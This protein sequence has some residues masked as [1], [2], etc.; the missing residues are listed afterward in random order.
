MTIR[1]GGADEI[2]MARAL[3]RAALAVNL[4]RFD[5]DV[6]AK[7]KICLLDFLSCAF[8]ARNHPWSRQ[9]IGIAGEV[10][11]GANIVGT[12]RLAT[13]GDAAFANAT[14]GHGL[15]REDMH[16]ASICH[17]GVVIWPTLLALSERTTLSGARLL[18]AAIIGYETGAQIGRA[19][20][21]ADLA[22]LYRP[23][24]LVAPLGAALAG[25]YA[26]GLT[27]DAATSAIAIAANT[28]SGLN[29]W[30]RAGGS[31]MYFH[32]GFAARNAI[33][34][35]ELA[36]AGALASETILEG[37]AGLFAAFR[38]QP[39]PAA[40]RLFA[41]DRPEIMAVYNKPAPAC[42]FAQTAAQAALRV[43]R[44]IGTSD[45]IATVSI[46]VPEAAARYPGCDSTGPFHNALQAK[47]SIPFSV[48]AVLARS[49]L[50]EDNYADIGDRKILRL[51][52]TTDLQSEAGLTAAFPANQGAEVVVA[53]RNGKTVRQHLDNVIAATPAEIRARFRLAAT[54][55][56]GERRALRLEELV[57]SCAGLSN[58]GAIATQCRL[59]PAEQRLRPA[60]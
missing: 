13:P 11:H 53:L 6:I 30:P 38:R 49:A 26:L 46:R 31:E 57:E 47:M 24:G 12:G 17:H 22:R 28:S 8:E 5:A 21:N 16:A 51:V 25:S 41:G 9:A 48:A 10:N 2:S 18:A 45:D 58:S 36:E 55:A 52:A 39:A 27:E 34:A 33:A 23:T 40:V 7:A 19:L 50:E 32:P 56:I 42:N 44:E 29:E 54:D 43:A 14:M 20:F 59:E 1:A 4:G 37:E 60:S 3:A 35:I 15:V